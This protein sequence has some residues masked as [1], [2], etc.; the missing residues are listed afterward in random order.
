VRFILNI[1]VYLGLVL[2]LMEAYCERNRVLI[3]ASVHKRA[4]HPFISGLLLRRLG[5]P[6]ICQN[7]DTRGNIVHHSCHQ[8]LPVAVPNY[9]CQALLLQDAP[10][11]NPREYFISVQWYILCTFESFQIVAR[12]LWLYFF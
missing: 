5:C 4:D 12:Y 7:L 10:G 11:L 9:K 1:R 2:D 8:N 6:T 3:N